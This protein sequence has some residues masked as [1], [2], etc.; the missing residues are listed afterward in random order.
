MVR[1][2]SSLHQ[3]RCAL[4]PLPLCWI[5]S[6]CFGSFL[7]F[8]ICFFSVPEFLTDCLVSIVE[9]LFFPLQTVPQ[10]ATWKHFHCKKKQVPCLCKYCII[11]DLSPVFCQHSSPLMRARLTDRTRPMNIVEI[12]VR[13]VSLPL[14]LC[15]FLWQKKQRKKT[16]AWRSASTTASSKW[17]HLK[18]SRLWK[19]SIPS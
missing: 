10:L 18:R 6:W 7:S 17:P 2:Q 13:T 3:C 19:M 8:L 15:C 5:R 12:T 16:H 14:P 1:L 4:S 11:P 9:D